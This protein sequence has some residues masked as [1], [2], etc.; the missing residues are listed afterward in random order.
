MRSLD[1]FFRQIRWGGGGGWGGFQPKNF[2]GKFFLPPKKV[3]NPPKNIGGIFFFYPPKMD[4]W[5][6][7]IYFMVGKPSL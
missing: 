7:I 4:G 5:V 3:S 2:R 6:K 1:D